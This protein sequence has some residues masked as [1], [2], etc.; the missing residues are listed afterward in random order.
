MT[1]EDSKKERNAKK[2]SIKME[3][4][5]GRAPPL[6]GFRELINKKKKLTKAY[7]SSGQGEQV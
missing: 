3:G 6:H 5:E 1:E 4:R 7:A 2:R